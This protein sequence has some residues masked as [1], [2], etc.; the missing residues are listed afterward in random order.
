MNAERLIALC[1]TVRQMGPARVLVG[2]GGDAT[3]VKNAWD[4]YRVFP[5]VIFVRD[6]G[7]SLGA[8]K[9]LEKVAYELWKDVWVAKLTFVRS[10]PN[11]PNSSGDYA[12]FERLT[13]T[14]V[15]PM[16][17]P[18]VVLHLNEPQARVLVDALDVYSR[19]HMG[20]VGT[21]V[22]DVVRSDLRYLDRVSKN[23]GAS[24]LRDLL[25]PAGSIL[26]GMPGNASWGIT[27]P[28]TNDT[29]RVAYD[30]QQV[31]RSTL[32]W[33][34]DPDGKN[35]GTIDYDEPLHTSQQPLPLCEVEKETK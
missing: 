29:A 34:K 7:W 21:A 15:S 27:N 14:A 25:C 1:R 22:M 20:Q 19:L 26:T 12:E 2:S 35:K 10:D 23:G 3:T 28:E 4:D 13:P 16:D 5:D 33:A 9:R 8:P 11:D 6:D 31:V 32:A 17:K 24:K 30:I 18:S